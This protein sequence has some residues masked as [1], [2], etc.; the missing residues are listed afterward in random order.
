MKKVSSR[1]FTLVE[2]LVVIA[3]IGILVGLLLP[4][5]Q[6]AREA[7]R[8][9][10]CTNNLKQLGLAVLNFESANKRLPPGNDQ[11]LNGMHFRILPYMEQNTMFT[12]WDNGQL[13]PGASSWFASGVAWN[14]PRAAT[15]P[16][17]RF[18]LDKPDLPGFLCPSAP[19]PEETRNLIQVTGV[20]I[21][22]RH[23]R[24]IF[25]LPA[26][27]T[28]SFSYFI[29]SSTS[30]TVIARTGITNYLFNRGSV[31]FEGRYEGPFR[32][33]NALATGTGSLAQFNNPPAVGSKLAV[34]TDGMSNTVFMMESAGGFLQWGANPDPARDGWTSMNW[35]HA[36]MYSDFGLCPNGS[37]GNC[38]STPR[39]RG[40]GWGLPGSLHAGGIVNTLFGDGS[41]RSVIGNVDY[42]T[43]LFLCGSSDGEIVNFE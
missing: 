15:P 27:P 43:F 13:S 23:F 36:P 32:Y 7:A 14:I 8:R 1:G 33:S 25:G 35:G 38:D 2:L 31:R 4:A 19:A 11:R 29:Y 30:P 18:A 21:P 16:Q 41:V 12:H 20:G 5:V 24:N 40:L 42:S 10:S 22:D 9:M 34:V 39:G 6:A 37:N 17:G 28:V 26:A 3:I